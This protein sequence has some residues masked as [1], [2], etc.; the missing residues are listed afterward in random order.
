MWSVCGT[1][2]VHKEFCLGD[3]PE[4][5]YLEYLHLDGR[6]ILKWNFKIWDGGMTWIDLAQ[7]RDK[8]RAVLYAVMNLRGP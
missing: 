6:I 3:L 7:N 1:G 5:G 2:E 4:R 8:W